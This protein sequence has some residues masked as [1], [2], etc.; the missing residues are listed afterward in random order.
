M[1]RDIGKREYLDFW[2]L[3]PSV[4]LVRSSIHIPSEEAEHNS[5]LVDRVANEKCVVSTE[6]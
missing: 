2:S 4:G 5:A 1:P 3:L 6:V